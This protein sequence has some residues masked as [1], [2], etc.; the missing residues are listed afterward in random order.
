LGQQVNTLEVLAGRPQQESED[1]GSFLCACNS[2]GVKT[3]SR[4]I[5]AHPDATLNTVCA[6]TKA[7]TGCGSCRIEIRRIMH[8]TAKPL[9][10]AE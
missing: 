6:E 8:E 7:G 3:I 2:V 4:F 10:A 9:A 1:H 5:R